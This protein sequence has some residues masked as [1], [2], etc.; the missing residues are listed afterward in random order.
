MIQMTFFG[1]DMSGTSVISNALMLRYRRANYKYAGG[2][3][4]ALRRW[5]PWLRLR[6][7]LGLDRHR[8]FA[9]PLDQRSQRVLHAFTRDARH[10]QRRFLGGALESLPLLL[11]LVRRHGV[12]LVQRHDLHLV[13]ELS[14]IS[15]QFGPHRLVGLC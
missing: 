8:S 2:T 10:Q 14:G 1:R 7:P 4:S 9:D 13:G 3:N 11:Q 6:P 5:R 15:F 12:D